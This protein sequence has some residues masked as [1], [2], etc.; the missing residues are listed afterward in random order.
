MSLT[1]VS[2]LLLTACA[3]KISSVDFITP[4]LEEYS[5]AFQV[6]AADELEQMGPP[7]DRKTLTPGCS[8][9]KRIVI[10]TKTL[11]DKIREIE[12]RPEDIK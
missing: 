1:L 7:C 6:Q 10:D 3:T 4:K 11:R 9:V 5:P 2:S 8:A 12:N